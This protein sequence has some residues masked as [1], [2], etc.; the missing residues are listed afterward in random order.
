MSVMRIE[1]IL[2]TCTV[3]HFI[4]GRPQVVE[5]LIAL[6]KHKTAITTITI[7][8][9]YYGLLT[10]GK[11]LHTEEKEE[12]RMAIHSFQQLSIDPQTA[13]RFAKIKAENGE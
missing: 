10:A 5:R 3:S 12:I 13:Y 9:A 11:K 2:D 6:P 8:E 7:A 1:Y 4:E